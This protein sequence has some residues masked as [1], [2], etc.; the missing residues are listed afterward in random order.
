MSFCLSIILPIYKVEQYVLKCIQS[1]INQ[2]DCGASIECIIVDDCSPDNSMLIIRS[3]VEDYHG[4]IKFV[5]LSHENNKGLSAARNT[6]ID[7]IHGDYVMFVDSDDWLPTGSISRFVKVLQNNPQID[8]VIGNRISSRDNSLLQNKIHE[9]TSLDN[10][11]IRKCL[12]N[13]Q[14]FTCSAWNKIIKTSIVKGNKFHEGIIFEDTPWA[15]FLFRDIKKAFIIPDVTY[16]Y[17]NNHPF[18][19]INTSK[20]IE[21]LSIH[22]K[23]VSYIGNAILDEPYKDL[24][25]DSL[26]YFFRLFIVAF[27]LQYE[28]NLDNEDCSQLKQLRKRLIITSF[29]KWR[30]FLGFFFF[31]LTYPPTSFIFSI[32]WVR[33][34]YNN[35][36]KTGRLIANILEKFH[37]NPC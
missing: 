29:R 1:I 30:F 3:L 25:A 34:H 18:S 15:F 4:N 14:I 33:K 5:F 13:Y 19:I 22:I 20:S 16:I 12:L 8:M 23:S 35:I 37:K 36:E 2:E 9:E 7:A 31:L 32:G 10:Y 26:F 17:E 11:Q 6:G 24:F 21:H 27:H 28:R